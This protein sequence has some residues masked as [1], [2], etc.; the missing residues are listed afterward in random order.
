MYFGDVLALG[1]NPMKL[2]FK[3]S[4]LV[5]HTSMCHQDEIARFWSIFSQ[6]IICPR[7]YNTPRAYIQGLRLNFSTKSCQQASLQPQG[8]HAQKLSK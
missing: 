6:S 2:D 3:K 1:N 7:M 5:T 4:Q 8:K